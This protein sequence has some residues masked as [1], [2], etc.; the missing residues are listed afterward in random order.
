LT[1]WGPVLGEILKLDFDIV[2]PGNGPV[3][4]RADLERFKT[5]IDTLV[6]RAAGLVQIGVAKDRLLSELN[7]AEPLFKLTPECLSAFYDELARAK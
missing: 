6:T 1:G 3:I 2:V 4:S 7:T 5:R